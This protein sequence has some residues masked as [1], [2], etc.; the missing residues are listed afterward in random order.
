VLCDVNPDT[1]ASVG[2]IP[3]SVRKIAVLG[4]MMELGAFSLEEHKK[5]V[6]LRPCS[7]VIIIE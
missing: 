5:I 2:R 4:D 7:D 6:R 3:K 1:D